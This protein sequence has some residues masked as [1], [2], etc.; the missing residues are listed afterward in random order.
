MTCFCGT[1]LIWGG[2]HDYEDYGAEG[3]GIVSNL[4]CPNDDCSC[5]MVIAYI[6]DNEQ[7]LS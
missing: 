2:D 4:S 3:N 5:Q 6:G 1:A 7:D